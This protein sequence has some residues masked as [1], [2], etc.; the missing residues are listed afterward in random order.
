MDFKKFCR[1]HGIKYGFFAEAAIKEKLEEEERRDGLLGSKVLQKEEK[2]ATPLR[3]FLKKERLKKIDLLRGNLSFDEK[4][5]EA[6]H[7]VR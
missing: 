6:R 2:R 3:G 1:E 4:V 5:L 7:H